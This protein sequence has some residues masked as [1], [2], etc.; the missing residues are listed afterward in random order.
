MHVAHAVTHSSFN[1]TMLPFPYIHHVTLFHIISFH[2]SQNPPLHLTSYS[3][4]PL[5]S[6]FT[7]KFSCLLFSCPLLVFSSPLLP[8]FFFIP[9]P[10]ILSLPHAPAEVTSQMLFITSLPVSPVQFPA[11]HNHRIPAS[12]DPST[13]PPLSPH[14]PSPFH[15]APAAA[16]DGLLLVGL[17]IAILFC[18]LGAT[19]SPSHGPV[20]QETDC[21]DYYDR[22]GFWVGPL[23]CATEEF[24]CGDCNDRICC[25]TSIQRLDRSEQ[26]WCKI[27]GLSP[28]TIAGVVAGV[29]LFAAIL[30]VACCFSCSCCVVRQ[31]MNVSY[32][33]VAQSVNLAQRDEGEGGNP[34]HQSPPS[35]PERP[36]P[37]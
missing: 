29:L 27:L 35:P 1:V 5:I 22:T 13:F 31:M 10:T 34:S 30:V 3:I 37:G 23:H 9:H 17:L 21:L 19:V 2:V 12:H 16:M 24:C 33:P 18:S 25:S 4:S 28:S 32:A 11:F 14:C 8:R 15:Q 6:F 7:L 36:L 26:N 20:D